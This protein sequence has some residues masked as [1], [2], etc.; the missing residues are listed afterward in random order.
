[1]E[2][3]GDK[4]IVV[5]CWDDGVTTD[6]RLVDVLRHYGVKA[7]FN[8]CAGLYAKERKF[9]WMHGDTEV[10]RLAWSE[11]RDLYK[12]FAIASHSLTHPYLDQLPF[13]MLR[14]EIGEGRERL[15]QFFG[16]TV[17]GF[18]YPFGAYNNAVMEAVAEA[19]HTYARAGAGD[20][21]CS[22]PPPNAMVF[23]P[24]CH[25]LAHDFWRRYEEAR[26][27]GVFYFWGH[28]YEMINEDMWAAFAE[29]IRRISTDPLACWADVCDLFD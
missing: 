29:T 12:G 10:W 7:T 9:G 13:D 14:E 28:S 11:M 3:V 5:Q 8:L 1:M 4:M 21:P 16:Q 6:E 17:E 19:G 22:L 24:S 27:Y 23:R 20:T 25:F 15:R 26:P 18:A 2:K